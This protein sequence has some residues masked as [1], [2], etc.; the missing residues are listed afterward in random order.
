MFLKILVAA[1]VSLPSF[2]SEDRRALQLTTGN[3][4]TIRGTIDFESI[5]DAQLKLAELVAV[6][7]KKQYTIYVVLDSPGGI[8]DAGEDFIQFAKRI[9]NVDT[10]S[11]F[12]ASMAAAI[13]EAMPGKRY[14]LDSSILMFHRAKGGFKGQFETGEVEAEL[15][16]SKAIVLRMETRNAKRLGISLEDY[17]AKVVNEYWVYSEAAIKDKVVDEIV[18][19]ECSQQLIDSRELVIQETMF[20]VSEFQF[21]GCPLFRNPLRE[22]K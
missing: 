9:P 11:I 14:A 22:K 17:K 2:A 6:R 21:S 10:I 7:G 13:T 19:I 3:T 12:A 18:D 20:G 15:A 4:V 16:L 5:T 1:A 8:I